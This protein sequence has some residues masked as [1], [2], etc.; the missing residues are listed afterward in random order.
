MALEATRSVL[1]L[2]GRGRRVR[3]R[4]RS[5]VGTRHRR[6]LLGGAANP[7]LH[8][9]S[10]RI[11][12]IAIGW[13]DIECRPR[14]ARRRTART[15][16]TQ[17]HHA[18]FSQRGAMRQA[19]VWTHLSNVGTVLPR[20]LALEQQVRLRHLRHDLA[21]VA[22]LAVRVIAPPTYDTLQGVS[23]LKVHETSLRAAETAQVAAVADV[24][25]QGRFLQLRIL[26]VVPE[27][28]ILGQFGARS[29]REVLLDPA[30]RL[31][32]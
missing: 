24:S 21:R 2:I 25:S 9:R 20:L 18:V 4:S 30:H 32:T 28:R 11:E 17:V 13:A 16:D 31:G 1:P 27:Y 22:V 6:N 8:R 14:V 19:A 26:V 5:R 7:Q 29:G 23:T 3:G 10:V 15:A 12:A